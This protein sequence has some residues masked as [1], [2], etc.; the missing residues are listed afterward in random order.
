V[1]PGYQKVT[2]PEMK[3]K[4]EK[5]WHV[6]GLSDTIGLTVTEMLQSAL[7]GNLRG[8]YVM[9]ENPMLSDPDVN[10][11]RR[12]LEKLDFLVVQDIFLTETA[13]LADVVLPGTSYAEKDGTFTAT[14]RR[15]QR[16]R[17]A[18]EPLGASKP[19]WEIIGMLAQNMDCTDFSYDSVEQIFHEMAEVTPQYSGIRYSKLE[20]TSQQWPCPDPDSLGTQ[21]LHV[22]TFAKGKGSFLP[23]AFKEAAELPDTRYPYT[24]TTGRIMFQFHTGTMSRRSPNLNNEV[25]EAFVE[26]NPK[27]ADGIGIRNEEYIKI[28]SR[29]GE[30][31]VRAKV[32][33]RVGKGIVFIPFHFAESAANVLTNPALDPVAKIPEFKVCAVAIE[34]L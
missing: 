27:D 30:I 9:G 22:G 28:I 1:Y 8:L 5:A 21:I 24:L 10:H 13:Q 3:E 18:I 4:F 34:A 11:V 17:K 31:K 19:D 12:C 2:L 16:V 6:T 20:E 33:E 32:T 26:I 29:R 23:I 7:Q 15:V 25:K 14:D